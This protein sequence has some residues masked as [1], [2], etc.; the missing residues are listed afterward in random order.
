MLSLWLFC[1]CFV[2]LYKQVDDDIEWKMV[3]P[4]IYAVI[5]AL[6]L[7]FVLLYKQVDDDIEWKVV[8]PDIYAVIVA[9]FLL[10]RFA[11]QTGR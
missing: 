1:Y 11:L 2:L 6:L 3:K 9:L 7:L 8:K 10:F 5:V 4:E